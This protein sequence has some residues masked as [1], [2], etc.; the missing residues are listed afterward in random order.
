MPLKPFAQMLEVDPRHLGSFV[1]VDDELCLADR[2]KYHRRIEALRLGSGCPTDVQISFDRARHVLLYAWFEYEL[3]VVAESLACATFELALK[4]KLYGSEYQSER[5]ALKKHIDKA[6][7]SGLL[8]PLP[9][10]SDQ[11]TWEPPDRYTAILHIRNVLAHGTTEIHNT[12]QALQLITWCA[13]EINRLYPSQDCAANA[14]SQ[15][16]AR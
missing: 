4:H 9:T 10:S 5:G 8:P 7:Q 3:L 11:T 6:R 16:S 2:A 13:N 1:Q 15:V 12:A 14:Q